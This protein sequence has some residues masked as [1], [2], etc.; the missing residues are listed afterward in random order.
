MNVIY[1]DQYITYGLNHR[2]S[3]LRVPKVEGTDDM[4]VY[5]SSDE[6][7]EFAVE[8]LKN[9][10]CDSCALFFV[11][12]DGTYTAFIKTVYD[13]E[14]ETD[15]VQLAVAKTNSSDRH[16]FAKMDGEL[17]LCCYSLLVEKYTGCYEVCT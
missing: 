16:M 12:K 6:L 10:P 4:L 1:V 3:F 5:V 8:T 9:H 17:R 11:H 14:K 13:Y 15:E 7:E 2:R